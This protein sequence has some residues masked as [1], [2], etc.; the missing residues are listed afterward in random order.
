MIA[1]C[2]SQLTA[3][4]SCGVNLADVCGDLAAQ[5]APYFDALSACLDANGLGDNDSDDG[6]SEPPPQT[7]NL[8][9]MANSCQCTTACQF[10]TCYGGTATDCAD[11]CA[12]SP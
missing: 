11:A 6:S 9:T 5:C 2:R 8:C 4:Y 1:P 10:C 12:V 3:L 7:G